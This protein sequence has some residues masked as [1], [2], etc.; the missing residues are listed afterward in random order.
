MYEARQGRTPEAKKVLELE[1]ELQKTKNYYNKRIREIEDKYKFRIPEKE[2]KK[3]PRASERTKAEGGN[4]EELVEKLTKER[5]L[6]AQKVVTLETQNNRRRQSMSGGA[7][8]Q[9]QAEEMPVQ[10]IGGIVH[11]L[12]QKKP[13]EKE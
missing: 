10:T 2:E 8:L 13:E 12:K 3:P 7:S 6:L 5:N 4:I 11:L 1:E 9:L